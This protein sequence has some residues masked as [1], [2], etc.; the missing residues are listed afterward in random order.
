MNISKVAVIGS[1]VMGSGIAAHVANAGV[2]VLLLDI[3]PD[4]AEDRSVLAKGAIERALKTDPAPFMHKR[5]AKLITPGN[6]EDDLGALKDCDWIIEVVLEN[7]KVKT[8]LYK[9]IDKARKKGS[10]VSSNTSSI[11]LANLVKDQSKDFK[12]DFMITHFFNPPRYLRLLELVTGP[13]TRKDAA[14]T[15]RAFCDIR[16][17]KGVVDAKDTPGFIANR[18][19]AYFMECALLEAVERGITPQEADIL[20]SRPVGIPKT[21]VFGLMDLV[22]IDLMPHLAESLIANLPKDDAYVKLHKSL[23]LIDK[24]IAD[25]YTGRKGKGGFYRLNTEGGKKI[26]EQIDL[27]TGEYAAAEKPKL[28]EA[29]AAKGGLR[30]MLDYDSKYGAYAKAVLVKSLGYAAS[31]VPEIADTVFAV[32]RAMKLGYAWKKGPFELMDDIGPAW[33]AGQLGAET[34]PLLDKVGNGTFYSIENGRRRFF[35]TDGTYHDIVRPDGVLLLED[36]RLAAQPVLKN[37]SA[38][39]WDIGDGVLCCEFTSK[40]NS[41]DLEIMGLLQQTI[42]LIVGS[43]GKYKALVIYNEADNFS[44]GANL[45]LALFGI[46]IAMWPLIESLI[47]LGQDTYKALKYA[48]FPVVCAPSGMA[49]GGGCEI[50]LHAD[51][52]QAHAETYCGLVEVGVGLIPGWGGC[53]EMLLRHRADPKTP[54]GPMPPVAKAFEQIGTAFVAKSADEAKEAKFFRE[55]DGITMNRERLLAD[56]KA[57]ALELARHYAPPLPQEIKLPG[58]SGK[59]ALDM[60]VHGF[61][62]NGKATPHDVVVSDV[63]ATV[64][65]GGETD[66]TEIVTEDDILLLERTVFMRLVK[67]PGTIARI[68]HMLDTGKPLRN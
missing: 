36:I 20:L 46:N 68:E 43:D 67:N 44:V 24:M 58:P 42:G 11:P 15:V 33:L 26:K 6:L 10:V 1:G 53:K 55:T 18:I 27:K 16:L 47:K 8:D 22:G 34:P 2:P 5:N 40:M 19:G 31:L 50:L 65:S 51:V 13:D 45:G 63:L 28:A 12:A 54:G 4:G 61:A 66:H 29:D 37:G 32:D 39:I 7:E 64:L 48:P 38:K 62:L 60:A 23:P 25:G 49:L 59:A 21:G 30:N 3:V 35:G 52:V 17:G 56:A 41:L 57:R 9:K 14:E